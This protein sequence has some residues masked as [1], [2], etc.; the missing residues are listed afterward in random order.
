MCSFVWIW[1]LWWLQEPRHL[2]NMC[3]QQ[4]CLWCRAR[5]FPFWWGYTKVDIA[6]VTVIIFTSY[7]LYFIA[8]GSISFNRFLNTVEYFKLIYNIWL[9]VVSH[10]SFFTY[11]TP[12]CFMSSKKSQFFTILWCHEHDYYTR[13]FLKFH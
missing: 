12:F 11:V 13:Y 2:G 3:Y 9:I 1:W 10:K 5:E 6:S 4:F 8:K 7:T